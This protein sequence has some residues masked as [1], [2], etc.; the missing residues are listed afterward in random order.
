MLEHQNKSKKFKAGSV[1]NARPSE[2]RN[3]YECGD[4][5]KALA[6]EMKRLVSLFKF[7]NHHIYAVIKQEFGEGVGK[8]TV[9]MFMDDVYGPAF[10]PRAKTL[11]KYKYLVWL[12]RN[13]EKQFANPKI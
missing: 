4:D 13:K 11:D 9:M 1:H 3:R 2:K 8:Q 7:S 12:L 6:K 5:V 10:R